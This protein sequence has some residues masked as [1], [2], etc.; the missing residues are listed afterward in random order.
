MSLSIVVPQIFY[1][2]I[3]RVVPGFVVFLVWYVGVLGPNQAISAIKDNRDVFDIWLFALLVTLSYIL[4]FILDE[5]W[6]LTFH[7]I[8]LGFILDKLWSLV[9]HRIRKN[10]EREYIKSC[11]DDNNKIRKCLRESNIEFKDED[12]PSVYAMHDHLR[13]YSESE[14]YRLLKV[15][16][17]V[18]LCGG[19]FMGFLFLLIINGLFWRLN[20]SGTFMLDRVA[21][22]LLVFLVIPTL[23]IGSNRLEKFYT[24]GT[25]RAWLFY[26]FPVGPLKVRKI[27][28]R[29]SL[30]DRHRHTRD[31]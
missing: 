8:K 10:K 3:A 30:R 16:A 15:R 4:G 18:R 22:E 27:T 31:A 21:L 17:E 13:L 20:D 9:F 12:L 28:A 29:P 11:I 14:A 2:L 6:S 25:C 5:L 23:W 7:K 1:D 26:N 19:L 24:I